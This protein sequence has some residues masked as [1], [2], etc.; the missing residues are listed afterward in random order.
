MTEALADP[1]GAQARGTAS[2]PPPVKSSTSRDG[3]RQQG[4]SLARRGARTHRR[5]RLALYFVL[6]AVGAVAWLQSRQQMRLE[7]VRQA[8]AEIIRAAALQEMLAQRLRLQLTRLQARLDPAE[9][10]ILA[11]N[12]IVHLTQ[13]QAVALDKLLEGQ[14]E[15]TTG[16]V[17]TQAGSLRHTIARW[18]DQ[19]ERVWYRTQSLLWHVDDADP[20][21]RAQAI[22][23]VQAELDAFAGTLQGLGAA[24][25]DAAERRAAETLRGIQASFVITLLLL[26]LLLLGVA[27]P[28]V[29]F[30]RAQNASLRRQTE[31]RRQL[32]LVAERTA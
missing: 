25:Q 11:L 2:S 7:Q 6:L 26:L 18:Q 10:S 28:L 24:L 5:V 3:T 23:R 15:V 13:T 31:Q 22:A 1:S 16:P 19:R 14:G 8:D 21:R 4:A 27:E 32:A 12:E 20:A 30:V 17:A 9:V 29:R